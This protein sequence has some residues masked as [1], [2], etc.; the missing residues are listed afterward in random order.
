MKLQEQ[1]CETSSAKDTH[2]SVSLRANVTMDLEGAG[3]G[4]ACRRDLCLTSR[5]GDASYNGRSS[6]SRRC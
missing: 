6:S 5:G 3:S 2:A 1:S 4:G